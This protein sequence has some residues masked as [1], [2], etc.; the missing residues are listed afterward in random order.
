MVLA[1]HYLWWIR[2]RN[3]EIKNITI[4]QQPKKSIRFK[5]TKKLI[6][7]LNLVDLLKSIQPYVMKL[8]SYSG[9]IDYQAIPLIS[10]SSAMCD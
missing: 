6:S 5:S 7:L 2:I 4:D 10:V 9:H 3:F 1:I 8:A